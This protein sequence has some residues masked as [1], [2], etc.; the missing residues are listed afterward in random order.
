[1]LDQL[2]RNDWIRRLVVLSGPQYRGLEVHC[3]LLLSFKFKVTSQIYNQVK[4]GIC[5]LCF[6]VYRERT[7]FEQQ[8]QK[9]ATKKRATEKHQVNLIHIQKRATEKHRVNLIHI[10]K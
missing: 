4:S 10:Q 6:A 7:K 9:R 1:M 2:H 3:I 8:Q 5:L